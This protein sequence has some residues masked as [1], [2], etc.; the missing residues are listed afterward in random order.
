VALPRAV[1]I[2]GP[3]GTGK[4]ALAIALD[5]ALA[6]AP[7]RDLK[8]ASGGHAAAPVGVAVVNF[9]SRQVYADFPVITAQ[10]SLEERA[11]CP[12]LLYGFAPCDEKMDAASFASMAVR[13]MDE[14]RAMNRLPVL[15]GGTGLY[16]KALLEGLAPIPEL[17]AE[18][19]A[20]VL[21][22]LEREG[23]GPLHR[24]LAAIDPAYA[25]KIH[26][27][28]SQRNARAMEV[29]LSTGRTMTAW[30]AE[31]HPA[32]ELDALKLGVRVDLDALTPRLAERIDAMLEQG[33][34][35]EAAA[36]WAR[37]PDPAAPGWS[38]IGC[39]ELLE[40]VRGHLGL[41]EARRL[42]IKHTRAYAKR[43]ITWCRKEKHM[44]WIDAGDVGRAVE[45]VLA[46]LAEG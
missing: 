35:E 15:V 26:P 30:H 37:C 31:A 34:V 38:G 8:R 12:H 18:I 17:S 19:R 27:N 25:A 13:A 21:A 2:L 39:A 43:Q 41:A 1:C 40:Y 3:T 20:S 29:W 33:A 7:N 28:D 32:A 11:A 5:R 14:A 23:P 24:E 42:W 36:A 16:L 46:W 44:F 22:R 9:D 45:L 10:P 4:T 6:I